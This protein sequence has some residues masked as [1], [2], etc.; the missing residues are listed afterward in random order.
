MINKEFGSDFH[1]LEIGDFRKANP[2]EDF[3]NSLGQLFFSGRAA[4]YHLLKMGIIQKGWKKIYVPTYYCHEVYK[5]IQ[6]LSKL[7]IIPSTLLKSKR[8]LL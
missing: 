1:W 4:L 2:E 3:V 7:F 5:Y 6:D 8:S